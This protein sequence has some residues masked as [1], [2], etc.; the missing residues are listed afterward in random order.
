MFFF[1]Y[2]FTKWLQQALN[3]KL[4]NICVVKKPSKIVGGVNKYDVNYI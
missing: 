4:T 2:N 1:H 3:Y